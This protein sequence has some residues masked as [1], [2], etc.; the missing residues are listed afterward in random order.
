[1]SLLTSGPCKKEKVACDP[2]AWMF[3]VN[4]ETKIMYLCNKLF[5]ETHKHE[6]DT[7]TD[8]VT[9]IHDLVD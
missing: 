8:Y 3:H 1:M 7:I 4:N 5:D 9:K 6:C 2:L